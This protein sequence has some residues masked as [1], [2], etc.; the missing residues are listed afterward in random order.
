MIFKKMNPA[1]INEDLSNQ[2]AF[3]I[4]ALNLPIFLNLILVTKFKN[5]SGHSY[6]KSI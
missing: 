3:I 2:S 5:I 6:E 1:T 4:D